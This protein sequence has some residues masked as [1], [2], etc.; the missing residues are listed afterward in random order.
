MNNAIFMS[1]YL[2]ICTERSS[3]DTPFLRSKDGDMSRRPMSNFPLSHFYYI[4]F[5]E[6][7]QDIAKPPE[8]LFGR[9]C[10]YFNAPLP[11]LDFLAFDYLFAHAFKFAQSVG[12][13]ADFIYK[14]E[15]DSLLALY[16]TAHV[17]G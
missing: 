3:V 12:Q 7:C 17:R 6:N 4:L 1:L 5:K 16:D 2:V 14:P 10:I 13:S 11:L 9:F 8:K 15:F